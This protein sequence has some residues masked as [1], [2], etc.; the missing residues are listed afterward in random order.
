MVRQFCS[1]LS[2]PIVQSLLPEFTHEQLQ[3]LVVL[4]AFVIMLIFESLYA[5]VES[6]LKNFRRNYLTNIVL[7]IFNSIS[8][9][10]LSVCSLLTIADQYS[11]GGL[12]SQISNPVIK[13]AVSFMLLDL[14]LYFWHK[15]NHTFNFLWMFH[16]VHH[17]DPFFNAS[18]AFRLHF[19]EL[20]LTTGIKALYIIVLGVDKAA[21]VISEAVI[22]VFIIFHHMGISVPGEKWLGRIIIVPYLHKVHHSV[23]REEHDHNYGAVFSIWDRVFN[24]MIEVKPSEIGLKYVKARSFMELLRFGFTRAYP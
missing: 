3:L 22:T 17:S 5:G 16:K 4:T 1:E 24:T 9:S 7:F 20:L 12:L 23:R 21:V 15:A 14:T 10:L 2:F 11:T 18:T 19:V 8:M 13:V 6:P